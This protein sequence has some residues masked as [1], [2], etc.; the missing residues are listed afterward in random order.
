MQS[1]TPVK[2]FNVLYFNALNKS[3]DPESLFD[4]ISE[5]LTNRFFRIKEKATMARYKGEYELE[6]QAL[7]TIIPLDKSIK[8]LNFAYKVFH[9]KSYIIDR[10]S[11]KESH[12]EIVSLFSDDFEKIHKTAVKII[13][14]SRFQ[15]LAAY[16]FDA[17]SAVNQFP[18]PKEII[19][20][21]LMINFDDPSLLIFKN[22]KNAN[23]IFR[24]LKE[25][26]K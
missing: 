13:L 22:Y 8:E 15:F 1:T 16:L 9:A 25:L 7:N 17:H 14:E 4:E 11:G 26:K 18:I 6:A 20:T 23:L 5:E 2:N 12:F 3:S 24:G 21:I 19:Y 10:Q